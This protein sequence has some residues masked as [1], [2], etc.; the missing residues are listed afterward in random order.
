MK[1]TMARS[2]V[3]ESQEI[4]MTL[5]YSVKRSNSSL[6]LIINKNLKKRN[7]IRSSLRMMW[8]WIRSVWPQK[9]QKLWL[10]FLKMFQCKIRQLHM[11][12]SSKSLQCLLY[13]KAQSLENEEEAMMR[14]LK[15]S[16]RIFLANLEKLSQINQAK[17]CKSEENLTNKKTSGTVILL[18]IRGKKSHVTIILKN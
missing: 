8:K 13:K 16:G 7:S 4:K 1:K 17:S 12:H 2:Y 6:K 5:Q 11:N 15:L 3:Q 10:R 14:I 9:Y 18:Q